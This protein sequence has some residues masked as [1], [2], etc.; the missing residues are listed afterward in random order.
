MKTSVVIKRIRDEIGNMNQ[1]EIADFLGFEPKRIKNLEAD[2]VQ[3]FRDDEIDKII[4]KT[5]LSRSF[6]L[7]GQDIPMLDNKNSVSV[8]YYSDIYAAAGHGALNG[9]TKPEIMTVSRSFLSN[10]FGL[11]SFVGIDII[12]VVGDSM[13]PFIPNGETILLQRT[14]EARNNQIVIAR[15]N[16]ELYVKRLLRDPLGRWVK[17]ISDNQQ[18]P[19]IDL[20]QEEMNQLEIIGIVYGRYRPF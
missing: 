3:K 1:Q 6:I 5:G 4:Q 11:S 12:H 14:H 13:E 8:N 16:D 15:I 17:L 9:D 2:A 10:M 19:D 20:N 18:Y 7:T